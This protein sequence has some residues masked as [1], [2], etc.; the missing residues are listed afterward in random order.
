M[1]SVCQHAASCQSRPCSEG[2]FFFADDNILMMAWLKTKLV[3]SY[4][5]I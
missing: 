2:R 5:R 4:L 1:S 3:S